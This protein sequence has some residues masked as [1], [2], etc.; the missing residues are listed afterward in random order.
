MSLK[1]FYVPSGNFDASVCTKISDV[2]E[3]EEGL[4]RRLDSL[5]QRH[6]GTI[7]IDAFIGSLLVQATKRQNTWR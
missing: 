4:P 2:L 1:L 7:T 6:T 5:R 3:L